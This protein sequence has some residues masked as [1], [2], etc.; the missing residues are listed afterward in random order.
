MK[1]NFFI[2]QPFGRLEKKTK[3]FLIYQAS[4]VGNFKSPGRNLRHHRI[5]RKSGAVVDRLAVRQG[6]AHG[7]VI[8]DGDIRCDL[9]AQPAARKSKYRQSECSQPPFLVSTTAHAFQSIAGH[10]V[11]RARR[12]GRLVKQ[13]S[14]GTD[15]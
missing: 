8:R 15:G 13:K 6:N 7:Y 5:R 3:T 10:E 12:M 14:I 2:L 9:F 4:Y 1:W 11:A